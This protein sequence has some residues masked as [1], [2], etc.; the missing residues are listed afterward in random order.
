MFD[1]NTDV[2][3]DNFVYG[4][5]RYE[6][7]RYDKLAFQDETFV[8]IKIYGHYLWVPKK[9]TT[10]LDEERQTMYVY[11]PIW[12]KVIRRTS[13]ARDNFYDIYF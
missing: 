12:Q 9:I 11:T 1:I 6:L 5:S 2:T 4:L 7:I 3:L 10:A 8:V 13:E